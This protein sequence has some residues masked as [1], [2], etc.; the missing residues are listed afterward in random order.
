MQSCSRCGQLFWVGEGKG[1]RPRTRCDGC[2]S[3]HAQIDSKMWRDLR[4]EF[5]EGNPSCAYCGATATEID[6]IIPLSL[7]G[8]P[9]DLGN[10]AP[11][12]KRCN[13]RKGARY[14]AVARREPRVTTLKW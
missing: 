5:L 1:G 11:A 10:L 3:I 12:C 14:G 6:H 13:G 8:D 7:G 2:R 9:Y 4:R